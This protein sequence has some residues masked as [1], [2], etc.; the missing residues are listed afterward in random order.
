MGIGRDVCQERV[1]VVTGSVVIAAERR[2]FRHESLLRSLARHV[3][4]HGA[5]VPALLSST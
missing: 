3:L 1:F 4:A 5:T 2:N